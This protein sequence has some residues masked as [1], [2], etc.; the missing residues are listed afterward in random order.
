MRKI[1]KIEGCSNP[2]YGQGYC[3]NHYERWR[4]GTLSKRTIP[5]LP[6]ERWSPVEGHPQW[7]ISTEGRVKSARGGHEKLLKPRWVGGRLLVG[8]KQYSN[9]TVHLAVLRAF[10]PD[11]EGKAIYKDGDP[12][13]V[14]LNNLQ[15]ETITD[16]RAAAIAMAEQS[17]SRWGVTFSAYWRGDNTALDQFLEEMRRLLIVVVP[18]KLDSWHVGYQMEVDDVI[19]TTLVRVFLSIHAATLTSLDNITAYVCTV[20]DRVLLGHWKYTRPLVSMI[21]AKEEQEINILDVAG[22][23]APSAELE[24]IFRENASS[25]AGA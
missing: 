7:Y 5:D 4:R 8:D 21:A 23:H 20:A 19:H 14:R 12:L 13:N 15:W 6:G 25:P 22:W 11:E 16:R 1:C 17:K 2:A 18:R 3:R 9:L 24:A 10:R